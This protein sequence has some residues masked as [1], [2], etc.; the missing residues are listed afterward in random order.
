MKEN[1]F[2]KKDVEN[3]VNFLNFMAQKASFKDWKT[4]DSIAHFRHLN[5]MQTILIPKI[6]SNILEVVELKEAKKEDK[7]AK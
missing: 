1:S 6:E 2:T 3:V 5:Y 4:E 7:K